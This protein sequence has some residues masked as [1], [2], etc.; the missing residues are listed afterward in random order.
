MLECI[1]F[2]KC[3]KISD[4]GI[5]AIVNKIKNQSNS[6]ILE[7]D[8]S[9]TNDILNTNEISNEKLTNIP[10]NINN[11]EKLENSPV[12][13]SLKK[14]EIL[15]KK[16]QEEKLINSI[17]FQEDQLGNSTKEQMKFSISE[18]ETCTHFPNFKGIKNVS[19]NN[20]H[21][22]TDLTLKSLA[23]FSES[24]QIISCKKFDFFYIL[25][26]LIVN[27]KIHLKSN[28]AFLQF[29]SCCFCFFIIFS[30]N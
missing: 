22:I 23:N 17:I 5:I 9:I 15:E 26:K 12:A 16:S 8:N 13:I 20:C 18:E 29:Q 28:L 25:G 11:E 10:D 14:E 1:R 2:D 30:R 19:L 3:K 7:I 27:K 6:D 21:K 24:L 4:G